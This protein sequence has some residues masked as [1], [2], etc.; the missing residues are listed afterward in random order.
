MNLHRSP[1]LAEKLRLMS[2]L[3]NLRVRTERK[4]PTWGRKKRKRKKREKEKKKKRGE[5][6]SSGPPAGAY[7]Y[8][9]AA[10]E[11]AVISTLLVMG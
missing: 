9:K 8:Y 11:H 3:P 7:T 6:T 10:Q 2:V 4:I 1:E 5:K